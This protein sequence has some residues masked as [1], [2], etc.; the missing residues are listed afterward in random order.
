MYD[1][2]EQNIHDTHYRTL[3]SLS[4]RET[5]PPRRRSWTQ[6]V[7]IGGQSC[8]ITVGE[9]DD[10]RPG[11]IFVDISKQGTFLRGVMGTLARTISLALQCGA[12]VDMIIHSLRGLDYEPAG[13]VTGSPNVTECFSV[14]DWIAQELAA[15]YGVPLEDAPPAIDERFLSASDEDEDGGEEEPQKEFALVKEKVAGY[16]SEDWRSGA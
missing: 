10:G 11:E 3:G 12:D 6:H 2:L 5:L 7:H 15:T 1:T 16:I 8:Y 14:T 13:P 9:Y 4:M